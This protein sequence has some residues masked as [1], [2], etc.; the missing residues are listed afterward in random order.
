MFAPRWAAP[1]AAVVVLLLDACTAGAARG[2]S[3]SSPV[4]LL[5]AAS[6]GGPSVPTR[7]AGCERGRTDGAGRDLQYQIPV[8]PAQADGAT[9]RD[10]VVHIPI[11]YRPGI[12]A[13]LVM[14]F[15]GAAPNATGAGYEHDSPLHPLSDRY[16]FIDVYPQG[17]RASTGN[18]GWNAY[19][20][21]VSKIA[22]LPFV[23]K[24][25]DTIEADFCVD[26]TRVYASGFSNGGNMVNYLACRD[27]G[28]FAAAAPV[29]GPMYGQD[30]GPCRPSR[31][32][33]II[34]IHSVDDPGV[35]YGGHPGLPN[36]DFPLPSVPQWLADWAGLDGCTGPASSTVD[37][38]QSTTSWSTCSGGARIV[39]YAVRAGHA[40]PAELD[41]RPA[42]EVVWRFLSAFQLPA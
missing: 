2:P 23:D 9:Q 17:L 24:L 8:D 19:G 31:P 3:G 41:G 25:L 32:V 10:A 14:Q 21:V 33:P 20:P 12:P 37:G 18:L 1:A 5:S 35:P 29:A 39:G 28:R 4:P 22:E 30:D 40:W 38:A 36:Y 6:T 26:A 7:P 42:A 34:D 27:S 15:H 13:P 11:G 16:G